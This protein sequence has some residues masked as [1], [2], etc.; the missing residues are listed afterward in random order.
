MDRPRIPITPTNADLLLEISGIGLISFALG[1]IGFHYQDLPEIIP[2][3]FNLSG[4][5]NGFGGK[6]TLWLLPAAALF[7][8]IGMSALCRYPHIFNYPV[9]VTKRNVIRQYKLAIGL[10]RWLKAEIALL[11]GLIVMETISVANG[12]NP[13]HP[14]FIA[15][16]IGMIF[17]SIFIY[18]IKASK[19]G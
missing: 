4:E 2:V 9:E 11:F 10:I 13:V 7:I 16:F 3:H 12:A 14:G 8:F 5:I 15:I 6:E 17:A 18:L 19:A 1:Y